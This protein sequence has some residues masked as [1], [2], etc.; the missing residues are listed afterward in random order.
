MPPVLVLT[1]ATASG[2]SQLA[3]EIAREWPVEIISADSAQVYRGMD[4]GTAKPTAQE[5]AQVPHHLLDILD[6]GETYSAARFAADARRLIGEI[7]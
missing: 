1:G 5:R 7:T 3:L 2:K 6:P 4:I